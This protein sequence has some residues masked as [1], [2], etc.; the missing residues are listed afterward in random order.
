MK[1]R[2]KTQPYQQEAVSNI[3]KV[4]KGQ[5]KLDMV[6]YTR[7]LGIKKK[8]E[9]V[10]QASLF[11]AY[12]ENDD[13]FENAKILLDETDI[14]QNIK[15]I[16]QD[17]NYKESEEL[18]KGLGK[19]SLDIE[20]ETGTGKTY[21][22]INTIFELNERYG[23]SKFIVVVP[24]IAIREGV[25]KSFQMMEDHFMDRY[26]KKARYFVYNS[27]RLPDLDSF[28]SSSDINVMI[29][30]TQAFNARGAD[31]R[32][33]DMVLDEFQSRKPIDVVAKTRP[34]LI[35]DEPQKM[36]DEKSATQLSLR[37]FN[38][39]FCM[40]FSATHKKQHNLV[41]CLD[42]VDA[43]NKCLVKKIQV[44]G[45]EI[46]NLR[47]TD[48]YLYLQDIVL[49]PNKP[50]MC[51]LEFEINYN[52]S[53]NR[54]TRILGKGD[55]L[56]HKSN[57][58][59]QYKN[60]YIISDINPFNNTITFLNGQVLHI[61]EVLGDVSDKDLRRIQIRETIRSHFEKEEKLYDKGIKCL[62]L[63][64][65]DE[66]I[67][68]RDYNEP[69]EKGEYARMFEEEYTKALKEKITL[70]ET[71]YIR[72]LKGIDVKDTHKG[73]FSI[74]KKTGRMIDSKENKGEG[75]D[76]ISAYDL[77]L[78]NKERL[79]SKEE[80]TRFIFSHSALREGW[81]NPNI[82]Q[83]CALKPGGD[84]AIAKRQ[85]VGRGLRIAVNMIGDRTDLHY[86]KNERSS[87]HNVNTLTV[88]ATDSYK[89][90]V[91]SIQKVLKENL[92]DRP[93]RATIEYFRGKFVSDGKE[94]IQVGSDMASDIQSYLRFN[95][96]ADKDNK[97]TQ[98]YF[99]DKANN[100]LVAMPEIL[101][102]YTESVHKLVES[103]YNEKALDGMFEDANKSTVE[104]N[105]LN[106]NFHKAEFQKLWKQI[107]HKYT[108]KVDFDSEELIKHSIESINK[109][110]FVAELKYVVTIGQQKKTM[111]ENA[112]KRGDSFST[113]DTRTETIRSCAADNTKYD[114]IGKIV[115]NTTLTRRTVVRILQ[116]ITREKF[117]MFAINPEEFITKVSRLINEQKASMIVDHITY[118]KTE[119]E[120][121]SDIFTGNQAKIDFDK[122]YK[123][124]KAIQD[125]V[126]T[127]GSAEES[128]ER[129][130]A[131]ELDVANEVCVYAKLP[132]S[133][134]IPT[135][136][137]NYAPDWAIAFNE[138]SVKHIYFVAETKGSMESL[139]LRG[140][141]KA[142]TDCA[143]KL[144]D[145]LQL[146]GNVRYEVV[147]SYES[148]LDKMQSID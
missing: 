6:R 22:Y 54:E 14:L 95:G 122:A 94:R 78:K 29:I 117:E 115:D 26:H 7:D 47:G 45:F 109:G 53:I 75:S 121:D 31:A 131:K 20:M 57:Q 65:I 90:F 79:L 50:P 111:D 144:F 46:K 8:A 64:F 63:F 85:E 91:G 93:T 5:P 67:K 38:P 70:F 92:A 69:D 138:G 15:H 30:N 84:S 114:L 88:I 103:I 99:D 102:P 116:G 80:P 74:D 86:F 142:K 106:D 124:Q 56:Y 81:D 107:N 52:K 1:F 87:F 132:R 119:G 19:C 58:M 134:Q 21:V 137:G 123:A 133:F 66:V 72:Y 139:E 105:P 143:K 11:D 145:Q 36:G 101:A 49:S 60:D 16:Q 28:A 118:N 42:A 59:E 23:W 148:L 127:D 9:Q 140:I 83:I 12:D 120:Y 24:S 100:T 130:F 35:L 129:K 68:Y 33:I 136:V 39:L 18:V 135:P 76:D 40:N 108:Y 4:F 44:K 62:S 48:K 41:Y 25:K 97:I 43:Y 146:A 34:I 51:K 89:D 126:V 125:Y 128:I 98:K 37:K 141:E 2:F 17:C 110:L 13:G 71:P 82:F 10:T 96:Y 73:Y 147:D 112:L 27:K 113:T 104:S 55:N 61:G 77:I 32:R 3:C